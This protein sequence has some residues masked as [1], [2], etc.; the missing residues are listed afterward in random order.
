MNSIAADSLS[1]PS[2]DF[3]G[4]KT[5]LHSRSCLSRQLSEPSPDFKGIKTPPVL[6]HLLVPTRPNQALIS[7][8]L[9]RV[10]F[11]ALLGDADVRTKP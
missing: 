8:G 7:K 11:D 2:P 4:I 1:E 10:N 5:L 3:K 6:A 9:R